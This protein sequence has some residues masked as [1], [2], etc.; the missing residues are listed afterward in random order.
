MKIFYE[1]LSD[2]DQR[3]IPTA[4]QK[5]IQVVRQNDN[6]K[7]AAPRHWASYIVYGR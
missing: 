1:K 7:F 4:L 2:E 3:D 5:T 6:G